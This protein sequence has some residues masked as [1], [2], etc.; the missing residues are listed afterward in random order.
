MVLII[1]IC[2]VVIKKYSINKIIININIFIKAELIK[3]IFFF[4][5]KIKKIKKKKK[6][7]KK[8]KNKNFELSPPPKGSEIGSFPALFY[9]RFFNFL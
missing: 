6:K 1:C 3:K 8:K 9:F 4:W 7:K 2:N 5:K